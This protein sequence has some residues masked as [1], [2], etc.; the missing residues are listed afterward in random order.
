MCQNPSLFVHPPGSISGRLLQQNGQVI[1]LLFDKEYSKIY[2]DRKVF[3]H[4]TKTN[5]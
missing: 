3:R 2:K 1:L 4:T 5:S